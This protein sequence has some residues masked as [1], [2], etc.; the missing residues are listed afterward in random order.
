M[1]IME[2]FHGGTI[3][4][5]PL[6]HKLHNVAKGWPISLVAQMTSRWTLEK[7]K[8]KI[9][10]MKRMLCV[11]MF[12]CVLMCCEL[13]CW[14]ISSTD[15]QLN[16][17]GLHVIDANFC[18]N[19]FGL[20]LNLNFSLGQSSSWQWKDYVRRIVMARACRSFVTNR[21]SYFNCLL[22]WLSIILTKKKK[23]RINR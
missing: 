21:H 11:C 3:F 17:G 6:A 12:L 18:L 5:S 23:K 15:Q 1:N 4:F 22:R 2:R 8:S 13:C 19:L 10:L 16:Y 14:I 9:F 7:S 20:I